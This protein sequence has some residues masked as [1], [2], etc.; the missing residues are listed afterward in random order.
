MLWFFLLVL[1]LLGLV[2]GWPFAAASLVLWLI[3]Y[4][5]FIHAVQ[6]GKR[7]LLNLFRRERKQRHELFTTTVS[8]L[9]LVIEPERRPAQA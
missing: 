3:G 1:I 2:F 9:S 4:V 8:E 5:G 6:A 7:E